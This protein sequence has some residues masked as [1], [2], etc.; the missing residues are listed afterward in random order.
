MFDRHGEPHF[1]ALE[2]AVVRELAGLT[3]HVIAL[4]GGAVLAADTRAALTAAGHPVVYL[5]GTPDELHRRIAADPATA[6]SRPSLTAAGGGLDE[7]RAVLAARDAIYRSAMTHEVDVVDRTV[8]Q[9]VDVL[10]TMVPGP[11]PAT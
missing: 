10:A 4:G 8:G 11:R 9:L 1:R 7:V 6:D 2:A 3:D 5:R